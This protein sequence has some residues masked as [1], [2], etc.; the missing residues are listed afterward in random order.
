MNCSFQ[1]LDKDNNLVFINDENN[2]TIEDILFGQIIKLKIIEH[3][4]SN[5]ASINIL[6]NDKKTCSINL[7]KEMT[8]NKSRKLINKKIIENFA[9]LDIDGNEIEEID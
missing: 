7:V 5:K 6:L 1:F 8:L 4:D 2:F 3:T 9:F